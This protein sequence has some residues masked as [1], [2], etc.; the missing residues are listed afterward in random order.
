MSVH[1]A[2]GIGGPSA[3]ICEIIRQF[4]GRT[5]QFT[6][7]QSTLSGH[8]LN[9]VH[10][11]LT[12]KLVC[13]VCA[14]LTAAARP[15]SVI[16]EACEKRRIVLENWSL[17]SLQQ[18]LMA[19]AFGFPFMPTK[20]VTGSSIAEDNKES[21]RIIENPFESG[22]GTGVV[23]P[24]IPDISIVHACV[25]DVQGN[26]ILPS[27]QGEDVW[28]PFA[29]KNGAIVTVEKI[30]PVDFIKKY[31]SFVK[32]PGYLVKAICVAPLGLHPFSLPNPGISDFDPYEK[33]ID[34]LNR[35]HE[36]FQSTS[37]LDGWIK[38]WVLDCATHQDYIDKLGRTVAA[39]KEKTRAI[40]KKSSSVPPPHRNTVPISSE[41]M[42]L[43]A[44]AREIV[45]SVRKSGH[46]MILA[47]AG[48]GA[49]AAFLAY[50]Q[51]KEVGVEID[52]VTGNGQI[53]YTPIPGESILA[54]EAGVRSSKMLTDTVMTQGVFVGG[55]NN[56][57]LSVLGA[58]QIDKYANINSTKTS[59]G[60]FL[61]G[62]GGAND[63][64]NAREVM[65]VLDQ[66]KKRFVEQLPYITGRGD[67]VS[68]VVSTMGIFRKRGPR[69]E[70]Y[71]AGCF[72]SI[73]GNREQRIEKVQNRCGWRL[74]PAPDVQD[75][76]EPSGSEL[77]LLR[78]LL[79]A[80]EG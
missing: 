8:A 5:P 3:A 44:L 69:R 14:D 10:C 48:V 17:L 2:G 12:K 72:T 21:F 67:N 30:V 37:I 11:G 50:Y 25:G 58:G 57:C 27:P 42:M 36:A 74:E 7:I 15:S 34:F 35:L 51:L 78:W 47:G 29:S 77:E 33:D 59:D 38:E 61:V 45:S 79:A 26:A 66:S 4:Y 9:L 24:L 55:E 75:I 22:K 32:I 43:V 41:E 16:Q 31:S 60:K 46:K 76:A 6:V 39:L 19:G 13:A 80:N 53:G 68:T 71:L 28:G 63:A 64:L 54:T 49:N 20:S 40:G 65:I 52:L 1:L 23:A 18:R 70:L 56:R 62:S 73:G